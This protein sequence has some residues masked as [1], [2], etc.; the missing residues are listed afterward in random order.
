MAPTLQY[1]PTPP[2]PVDFGSGLVGVGTKMFNDISNI[3]TSPLTVISMTMGDSHFKFKNSTDGGV[4][5]QFVPFTI[6]PGFS[7]G[8]WE[9]DFIPTS[10]A[11]FTGSITILSNDPAGP[12]VITLTGLGIAGGSKAINVS[13]STKDYGSLLVGQTSD[14]QL[15]TVTT[16]GSDPVTVIAPTIPADF[17]D[18]A[19]VPSYPITLPFS[20][21]LEFVGGGDIDFVAGGAIDYVEDVESFE[22]GI[23]FKPTVGFLIIETMDVNSDADANPFEVTLQG[24]GA[25][26]TPYGPLVDGENEQFLVATLPLADD[27]SVL[28]GD[29]SDLN[30]EQD[31]F[32]EKLHN[33][34]LPGV[35]KSTYGAYI[36][37]EDLNPVNIDLTLSTL[38]DSKTLNRSMG[39]VTPEGEIG[40]TA[41]IPLEV[42]AELVKFRIDRSSG[43]GPL[44]LVDY[45]IRHEPWAA[46]KGTIAV[47]TDVTA[48]KELTNPSELSL[49]IFVGQAN[50]TA[51]AEDNARLVA[52]GLDPYECA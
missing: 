18:G 15:F 35:M 42:W 4:T 49:M 27:P 23:A 26:I 13:P 5:Y 45:F 17:V 48:Y 10:A 24:Y 6:N 1:N 34:G 11:T 50:A 43:A 9:I 31:A 14:E 39:T 33:M 7:S 28:M 22:F 37:F 32:I 30:C 38:D 2:Y 51:L 46:R 19:T 12:R 41:F 52:C 44:S 36:H 40:T 16:T 20:D 25:P 29:P 8:P 47:P 21:T 3:G